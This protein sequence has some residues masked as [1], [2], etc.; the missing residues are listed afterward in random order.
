[1]THPGKKSQGSRDR[2]SGQS[3]SGMRRWLLDW[4]LA[5]EPLH[6]DL[7]KYYSDLLHLYRKYPAL[8]RLERDWHGFQWVNANDGDRSIFSHI[9]RD[10]T[11][12]KTSWWS[13][14]SP[15]GAGRLLRA[16]QRE[17]ATPRSWTPPTAFTT[18]E[19]TLPCSA[20]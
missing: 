9:R 19:S 8:Y 17:A 15:H 10:E 14:I 4:Y 11:G 12:K 20:Q 16:C 6:A 18:E 2:I 13:A 1:M 7:Q 3:T 5:E